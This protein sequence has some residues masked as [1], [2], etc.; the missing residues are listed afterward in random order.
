MTILIALSLIGLIVA[1]QVWRRMN[2]RLHTGH[3][4][5]VPS[6]LF[7]SHDLA[8]TRKGPRLLWDRLVWEVAA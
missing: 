1:R 8:R 4:Q 3:R 7:S 2:W 6:D 5:D